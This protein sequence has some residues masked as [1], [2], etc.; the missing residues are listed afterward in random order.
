[1]VETHKSI[2]NKFSE[3]NSSKP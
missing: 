2:A 1:M 3:R